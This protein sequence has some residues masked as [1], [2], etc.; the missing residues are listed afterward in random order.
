MEAVNNY[1][2]LKLGLEIQAHKVPRTD[3]PVKTLTAGIYLRFPLHSKLRAQLFPRL[4]TVLTFLAHT[5]LRE[6]VL[7]A[8]KPPTQ[9]A[10]RAFAVT[11]ECISYTSLPIGCTS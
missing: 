4:A 5:G 7:T 6:D 9:A 3:V 10:A 2:S 11:R 1:K 8:P